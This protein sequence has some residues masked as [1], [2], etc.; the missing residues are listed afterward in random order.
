LAGG[1]SFIAATLDRPSAVLDVLA[2]VWCGRC[3]KQCTAGKV[4]ARKKMTPFVRYRMLCVL[5]Y[6]GLDLYDLS[7]TLVSWDSLQPF[8]TL[9]RILDIGGWPPNLSLGGRLPKTHYVP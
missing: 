8:G 6:G 9:P 7:T 4:V 5:F 1:P 2:M 3:I